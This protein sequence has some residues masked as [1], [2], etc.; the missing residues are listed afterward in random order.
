MLTEKR[1]DLI[2]KHVNEHEMCRLNEL[3]ELTNTS[4][5]TIRRDLEE[6]ENLG[7]VRRIHGGV[8]SVINLDQDIKQ[9]VRQSLNKAVKI[10]LAEFVADKYI[11]TNDVVYLDAGTTVQEI[12]NYLKPEQNLVIVTNGIDTAITATNQGLDTILIGGQIK[13]D[14][15]AIVGAS[16][17]AQINALNFSVAILG[18]NGISE[19]A[20]ITTPDLKEASLKEAVI[21]RAKTNIVVADESKIGIATFAKFADFADVQLVTNPLSSEKRAILPNKLNLEVVHK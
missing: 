18:A 5:S 4:E 13:N 12:I 11:R 1:K 8:R 19:H 10:K 20:G 14:T 21:I 16:A 2:V 9:Q 17:I 6:L 7:L 3:A 15:R